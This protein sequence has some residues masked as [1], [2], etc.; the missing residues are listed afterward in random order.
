MRIAIRNKTAGKIVLNG[1]KGLILAPYVENKLIYLEVGGNGVEDPELLG[2]EQEG[3]I[4]ILNA[5]KVDAKQPQKAVVKSQ[6]AQP[7]KTEP[8]K[9]VVK[10]GP[11]GKYKPRAPKTATQ[12]QPTSVNDASNGEVTI[13]TPDGPKK[14][15]MQ[16]R[17]S[18]EAPQATVIKSPEPPKMLDLDKY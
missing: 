6:Q 2:L 10:R 14:G 7:A 12:E 17:V 8:A 16:Y 4:E 11:R 15:R 18:G 13:M 9:Q 1:M 5:E 3:L